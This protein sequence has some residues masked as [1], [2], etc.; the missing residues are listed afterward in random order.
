MFKGS[1]G[2]QLFP[3]PTISLSAI[4]RKTLGEIAPKYI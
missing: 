2:L 3:L 4:A 1:D